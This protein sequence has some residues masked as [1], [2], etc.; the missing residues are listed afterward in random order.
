MTLYEHGGGGGGGGG[1]L[2]FA[3]AA[4]AESTPAVSNTTQTRPASMTTRPGAPDRRRAAAACSRPPGRPPRAS[5]R[6]LA[7]RVN[8]EYIPVADF[9]DIPQSHIAIDILNQTYPLSQSC[10]IPVVRCMTCQCHIP[11][12]RPVSTPPRQGIRCSNNSPTERSRPPRTQE[13]YST[14][15]RSMS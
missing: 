10:M 7:Q 14:H 2:P 5:G 11:L 13:R 1:C 6:V 15:A 3:S 8:F 4:G 12:F 9:K